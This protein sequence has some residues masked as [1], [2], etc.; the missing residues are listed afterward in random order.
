METKVASD[1]ATRIMSCFHYDSKMCVEAAG[2]SGGIWMFWNSLEL[3]IE[4]I[5]TN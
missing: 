1:N 2:F 4:V 3:G 5:G